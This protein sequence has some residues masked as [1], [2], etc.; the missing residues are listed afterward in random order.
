MGY[1][2]IDQFDIKFIERTK[3]NVASFSGPNKFTHLLNSL[4]GLIFVPHEF[5]N[6]GKRKATS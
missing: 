6:K 3:Q 1:P 5:N 2:T 4:I